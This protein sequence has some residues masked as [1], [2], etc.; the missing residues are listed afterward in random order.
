MA[1]GSDEWKSL[2][3]PVQDLVYFDKYATWAR[4]GWLASNVR[5]RKENKDDRQ[6]VQNRAVESDSVDQQTDDHSSRSYK[7]ADR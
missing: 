3:K 4:R 5:A 7:G 6:R 2:Y 1:M